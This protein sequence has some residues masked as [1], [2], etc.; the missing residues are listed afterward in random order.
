MQMK[1]FLG[2]IKSKFKNRKRRNGLSV[3]T[4]L[5]LLCSIFGAF[6]L[7]FF[8]RYI[9]GYA[10]GYT[11]TIS[12]YFQV[13][14][15]TI[16][17]W[18]PFSIFEII[19][20]AIVIG[21]ITWIVL[22]IIDTVKHGIKKSYVRIINLGIILCSCL[23]LYSITVAPNY[24]RYPVDIPVE[25]ELIEDT[26][27][28]YAIG[29]YYQNDFNNLANEFEFN[30]DGSMVRPCS[31]NEIYDVLKEE[32]EK[33][34]SDYFL[35]YSSTPK[36]MYLLSWLYSQLQITG[37][38]FPITNEANFNIDAPTSDMPFTIAHEM[39]HTK[40]VMR[41]EDANLV[42]AYICLN[43]DNSYLRYSGYL[44]TY[45]SLYSLVQ[46]TNNEDMYKDFCNSLNPKIIKDVNY[47][48]NYWKSHDLL[49]SI[50]KFF[51]D[52]YLML[53]QSQTTEAYVD[54]EDTS[55]H[56]EGEKT[57]YKINS[58]SPYQGLLIKYYLTKK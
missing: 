8:L 4:R 38:T 33:L 54:H 46:A 41:E 36:P 21:V 42:A 58:Y 26:N 9:P 5:I 30:D 47:I 45:F 1:E 7:F 39:A 20:I 31:Y 17:S 19:V 48:N 50:S 27:E 18:I 14:N 34:D 49:G 13:V 57:I 15:G 40:G 3:K 23:L 51:N 24:K 44:T 29:K 55:S 43:S 25:T 53:S 32:Y 22:F 2:N 6:L 28:Y 56:Q 16:F 37:V 12:R 35:S 11:K 10:E 52:I